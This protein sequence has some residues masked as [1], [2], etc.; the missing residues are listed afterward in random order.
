MSE[1][2]ERGPNILC[3]A[4]YYKGADFLREAHARG[5]RVLLITKE[6]TL[7][8]D[9]PRESLEDLVALP[10][11]ATTDLFIQAVAHVARRVQLD[12]LV[13]LEEFDVVNTAL[14]REHLQ[15]PGMTAT[16]ARRFRDKL[17]MRVAASRAGLRVPD[18]VRLLNYQEVGEFMERVTSPWVLKPR[19]DVSAIGIKK[20]EDAE[21]VWRAMDALDERPAAHERASFYLLERYVPGEV[22]HVD[23]IVEGGRITFAGASRYGRPPMDVSHGGGVFT[24]MTVEYD[25][26]EHKQLLKMNA[27]LLKALGLES[28][29]THAEFI[30][31][32]DDGQLYFLEVAARVGGAYISELQEAASG[33]NLWRDW[34]R[35]ELAG[36]ERAEDERPAPRRDYGGIVLSLARQEWPDTSAYQDPE[37]VF[38][39]RKPYHVGLVVSSPSLARV[40]E[41]LGRYAERFASDFAAVVPPLERVP[42]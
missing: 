37:I 2:P 34:A 42:E 30:R 41:L 6:R 27:K 8:E 39:V 32:R 7:E 31:G 13:A 28:G 11:D 26:P 40:R 9:W 16:T 10:N 18:F 12:R 20:L 38:R 36:G 29:A 24:S 25:T 14:A 19:S 23:A 22:F 3:V 33:V 15:L 35:V 17:A 4:S 21:Q 1:T 5:A